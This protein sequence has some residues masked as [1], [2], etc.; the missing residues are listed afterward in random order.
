MTRGIA[1]TIP[2]RREDEDV[3]WLFITDD[4]EQCIIIITKLIYFLLFDESA[5]RGVLSREWSFARVLYD[6]EL[7]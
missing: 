6:K 7:L 5:L 3:T 4:V 1:L 2:P